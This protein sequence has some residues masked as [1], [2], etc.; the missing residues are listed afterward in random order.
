MRSR[1]CYDAI[2]LKIALLEYLPGRNFSELELATELATP[3]AKIREAIKL[4]AQDKLITVFPQR[5]TTISK[6]D[7]RTTIDSIFIIKS[8]L[9]AIIKDPVPIS[10]EMEVAIAKLEQE[11]ACF[12]KEDGIK[13]DE[14]FEIDH[15]FYLLICKLK[16]FQRLTNI[17]FKEKIHIDRVIRLALKQQDDC[18]TIIFYYR[19]VLGG[20]RSGNREATLHSLEKLAKTV[21]YYSLRTEKYYPEYF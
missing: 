20:I 12:E 8:L 6:L 21:E 3:R 4:L 17:I 9:A 13:D 18:K 7:M 16:P 1:P 5:I 10:A 11:I 2:K 19:Q 15:Q 14:F